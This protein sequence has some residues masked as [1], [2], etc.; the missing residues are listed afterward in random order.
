[1]KPGETYAKIIKRTVIERIAV[2]RRTNIQV[3]AEKDAKGASFREVYTTLLTNVYVI[4]WL[5]R[6]THFLA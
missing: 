1:M 5:E 2:M 4:N 6:P 3:F